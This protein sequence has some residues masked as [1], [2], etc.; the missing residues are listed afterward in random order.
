[1]ITA[2]HHVS[3][4]VSDMDRSLRFYGEGLGFE[5]LSDREA[6]GRFPEIVSGLDG[7]HLREPPTRCTR[8]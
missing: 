7:A 3:Y 6:S 8:R 2:V 1:M 5:V 4:T